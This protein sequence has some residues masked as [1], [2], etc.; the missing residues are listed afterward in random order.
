MEPTI[1]HFGK[2]LSCNRSKK[3][4]PFTY[5]FR[6]LR[7]TFVVIVFDH[8]DDA[9]AVPLLV[10][11]EDRGNKVAGLDLKTNKMKFILQRQAYFWEIEK[12]YSTQNITSFKTLILKLKP[13]LVTMLFC[14]IRFRRTPSSRLLTYPAQCFLVR[15]RLK[16]FYFILIQ[17]Y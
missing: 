4:Q 1:W 7:K 5:L 13:R 6:Y 3:F 12:A 11:R 15:P 9:S 2:N 17:N 8:L 16:K 14:W 10:L